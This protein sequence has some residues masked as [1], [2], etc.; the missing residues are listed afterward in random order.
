MQG[1]GS[2]SLISLGESSAPEDSNF[3]A[4]DSEEDDEAYSPE[5]MRRPY[6][7]HVKNRA[8]QAEVEII[9]EESKEPQYNQQKG[10]LLRICMRH[11]SDASSLHYLGHICTRWCER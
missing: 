8:L 3:V 1:S 5:P 9:E 11:S 10:E 2:A 4:S 7:S 6:Q